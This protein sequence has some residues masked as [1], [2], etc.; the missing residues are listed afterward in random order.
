MNGMEFA[1]YG[2]EGCDQ[3]TLDSKWLVIEYNN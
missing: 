2:L 3:Q 1:F